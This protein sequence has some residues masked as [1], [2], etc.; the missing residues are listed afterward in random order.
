MVKSRRFADTAEVFAWLMGF[1]NLEK[2]ARLPSFRIDRMVDL[3][4]RAGNPERSF[5]AIHVAG[6]KG[7]GSVS[8]FSAYALSAHGLR[9]GLYTSP[10]VSRFEERIRIDGDEADPALVTRAACEL[11]DIVE[12]LESRPLPDGFPPTFFELV[13]LLAFMVFM[14]AGC[15]WAAIETGMGGRLDSTNIIVPEVS[16]LCPIELEH[17]EYLGASI[18]A[19]ASE[20]AGIIKPGVPAVSSAQRP[21][22]EAV[23]RARARE[24]GSPISFAPELG[25][26]RVLGN[27]GGLMRARLSGPGGESMLE[28]SL[29]LYGRIQAE[30][31]LLAYHAVR[32]ALPGAR[33][34][35]IASG[36]ARASL[37]A[38]F[39]CFD[40]DPPVVI[41]GAHTPVSCA[42]AAE[43]FESLY[44][45][46]G[47]LLF[48]CAIDKDAEGIARALAPS[49]RRIVITKP[50]D[51]KKSDPERAFRAFESLGARPS[52]ESDPESAFRLSLSYGEPVLVVGSFYLAGIVR[53]LIIASGS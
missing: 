31:A 3:A 53:P 29:G 23:F 33:D 21:E 40:G 1:A 45:K 36:F 7:K 30:N 49:F 22:A 14:E 48:A 44:G 38:R 2:G 18:A 47:S 15:E 26:A 37:P 41:D 16:A 32:T 34:S 13:T 51:F 46:E 42:L 12:G 6:S 24:L 50:G 28:V 19:I 10:H 25:S 8:A 27:E 52:L 39:E 5:R 20:K 4:A 17:T 11:S 43:G 35:A 9:T